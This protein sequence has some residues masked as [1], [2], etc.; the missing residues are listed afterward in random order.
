MP[1]SKS[2]SDATKDSPAP[3]SEV[4]PT[5]QLNSRLQNSYL[6]RISYGLGLALGAYILYGI[7]I[8]PFDPWIFR[9]TFLTAVAVL[10]FLHFPGFSKT[11]QQ[12]VTYVD[13]IWIAFA[14]MPLAYLIL[15]FEELLF[16][17]AGGAS[18]PLDI[19]FGT[20]ATIVVLE[21]ARRTTGWALPIIAIVA[22]V[23]AL[24]GNHLPGLFWNKGY[25]YSR[26]IGFLYSSVGIY[27]TPL[28]VAV[29]WVFVFIFFGALLKKCGA[30]D[31]FIDVAKATV[32]RARG[33]VSKVPL[34]SSALFGTISGAAV[35]NVV[36]TGSITIPAMKKDGVRP[37]IAGAIE[38]AAS[39]GGQLMPPVMGAAAFLM[40][41]ILGIPY[42]DIITAAIIPACLYYLSIYVILDQVSAKTGLGE[43]KGEIP[44]LGTLI[45]HQGYLLLPLFAIIFV[46]VVLEKS[47]N[48]AALIGILSAIVV[49]WIGKKNRL[50]IRPIFDAVVESSRSVLE[51]AAT[52]A[53]AGI[54]IGILSL[55][56][57]G[58]KAASIIISFSGESLFLALFLSMIICII[59]GLGLPTIAAY[60]MVASVVPLA[61]VKLGV[62]ELA[63]HMF[64]FY[65][66]VLATITPPVAMAS[67]AAAA[68]AQARLWEV[69]W[70]AFRYGL[71]G[72]IIPYMF[73]FGE[74]LLLRGSLT[75]I[76][77]STVSAIVG[78]IMLAFAMEGWMYLFGRISWVER[79][80]LFVAA[81]FM[82]A[83]NIVTDLAG[84]G[85]L[86]VVL[87]F[88]GVVLKKIYSDKSE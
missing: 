68:I 60:A 44:P 79:F 7:Y 88:R 30:G 11:S 80:F 66:C 22:I 20:I 33:G 4:E 84:L 50:T 2:K 54:I 73:V 34:I 3:H 42:G 86:V 72:F 55:T 77:L 53:A 75:D 6:R 83:Q 8:T 70:T 25:D 31:L 19:L 28:G 32:G 12:R 52:T 18:Q 29:R 40:A 87:V 57:L 56:G 71:A 10:V 9:T 17:A 58:L 23:Y 62:S 38:A 48:R 27:T 85:I 35:A 14:L 67:F 36:M 26:V 5:D 65:F 49:S 64:I 82:M 37:Y 45:V 74:G 39:T 43:I 46:L 24:V 63:A 15:S 16:R 61:L 78:V 1:S 21:I 59:L 47:P 76:T 51:I 41:D 13:I 69:G 81:L